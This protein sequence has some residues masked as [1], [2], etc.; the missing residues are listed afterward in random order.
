MGKFAII[1]DD[2]PDVPAIVNYDL[3][4]GATFNRKFEILSDYKSG[5]ETG[6]PV[7]LRPYLI[8]M[9][10]RVSPSDSHTFFDFEKP[11]NESVATGISV[12]GDNHND[13]TISISPAITK[14]FRDRQITTD[15]RIELEGS[16]KFWLR[17]IIQSTDTTTRE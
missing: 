5:T 12:S 8:R 13:L 3:Y 11:V 1:V 6:D 17:I 2:T 15:L 14:L 4:A 16:V 9:Q 10:G 7:D